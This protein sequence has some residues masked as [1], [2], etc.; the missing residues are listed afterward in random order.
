MVAM[1]VGRPVVAVELVDTLGLTTRPA[2]RLGLGMLSVVVHD[3]CHLVFLC[4]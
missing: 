3:Q 2:T 4:V 1:V